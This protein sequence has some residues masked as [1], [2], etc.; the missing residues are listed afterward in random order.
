MQKRKKGYSLQS[1][2]KRTGGPIAM[3]RGPGPIVGWCHFSVLAR[4]FDEG[5]TNLHLGFQE[6]CEELADL[7]V[8]ADVQYGGDVWIECVSALKCGWEKRGTC[9][10]RVGQ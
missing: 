7:G 5:G 9:I 2:I 1:A 4:F 8:V 10:D 3:L 6:A